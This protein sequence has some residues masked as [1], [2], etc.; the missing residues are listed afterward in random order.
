MRALHNDGPISRNFTLV[1]YA[2]KKGMIK[3]RKTKRTNIKFKDQNQQC[4]RSRCLCVQNLR[5]TYA[6]E[7]DLLKKNY[8]VSH[9]WLVSL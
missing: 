4:V 9:M 2:L 3:K 5:T 6:I 8:T 1:F 7:F